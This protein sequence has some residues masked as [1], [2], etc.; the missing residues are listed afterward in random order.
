MNILIVTEDLVVGG[1]QVFA[2]RLAQALSKQYNVHLFCYLEDLIIYDIVRNNAP[3]INLLT[4]RPLGGNIIRLFDRILYKLKIDLSFYN[5]FVNREIKRYL[6]DLKID[7]VHSH[8][9][10]VDYELSKIFRSLGIPWV[11]TTH[12][13]HAIF[14]RNIQNGWGEQVYN[15]SSKLRKILERVNFVVY[16]SDRQLEFPRLKGEIDLDLHPGKFVKIYNGFSGG[17][18]KPRD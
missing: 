7:I 5:M 18:T 8:A 15:Y 17:Y 2:L 9:F 11:I 6:H 14:Y 13:D 12:G 1:A 4:Y 3:D 16:L 10:K